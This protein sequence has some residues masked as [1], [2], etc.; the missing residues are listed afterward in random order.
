MQ[1]KLN[2]NAQDIITKKEICHH[3]T[4]CNGWAEIFISVLWK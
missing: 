2:Y 1:E 4:T 3:W